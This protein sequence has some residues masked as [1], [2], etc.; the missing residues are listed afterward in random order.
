MHKNWGFTRW[1]ISELSVAIFLSHSKAWQEIINSKAKVAIVLEDDISF[2]VRFSQTIP[3]LMAC[4]HQYDVLRI[5]T[6]AQTRVFGRSSVLANGCEARTIIQE[7]ADA[8]AYIITR[9]ACLKLIHQTEEFCD[10][11]DDFLFSPSRRLKTY[12]LEKPICGQFIHCKT[13]SALAEERGL[14]LSNRPKVEGKV[15]REPLLY[16]AYKELVRIRNRI[17]LIAARVFEGAKAVDGASQFVD[18]E[19]L[20]FQFSPSQRTYEDQC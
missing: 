8:G 14:N 4:C 1:D 12:Q 18:M 9:S 16:R 2:D 11:L 7:M 3:E 20:S 15:Q 17:R 10:H 5:N 13:L 6:F 19:Y